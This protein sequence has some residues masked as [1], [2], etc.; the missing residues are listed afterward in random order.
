MVTFIE[1][2]VQKNWALIDCEDPW[3]RKKLNFTQ[4][5]GVKKVKEVIHHLVQIIEE[6]IADD[7]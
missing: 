5:F 4:P 2:V 6:K 7:L 1:G 3:L